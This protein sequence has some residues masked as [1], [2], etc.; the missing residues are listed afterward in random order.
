MDNNYGKTSHTSSQYRDDAKKRRSDEYNH[1]DRQH[2]HECHRRNNSYDSYGPMNDHR[3]DY[4]YVVDAAGGGGRRSANR[5]PGREMDISRRNYDNLGSLLDRGSENYSVGGD[6]KEEDSDNGRR[7]D[8]GHSRRRRRRKGHGSSRRR[9]RKGYSSSSRARSRGRRRSYS[10]SLPRKR[11]ERGSNRHDRDDRH[12][13]S[14]DYRISSRSRAHGRQRRSQSADDRRRNNHRERQNNNEGDNSLAYVVSEDSDNFLTAMGKADPVDNTGDLALANDR[15]MK[16]SKSVK[17]PSHR[18]DR[19][20]SSGKRR[21]SSP[22][23]ESEYSHTSDKRGGEN[24]HAYNPPP[25][26]LMENDYAERGDFSF[27]RRS[28]SCSSPPSYHRSKRESSRKRKKKSKRKSRRRHRLSSSCSLSRSRSRDRHHHSSYSLRSLSPTIHSDGKR[29]HYSRSRSFSNS[30]R[31]GHKKHDKERRRRRCSNGRKRVKKA[32]HRRRKSSTGGKRSHQSDSSKDDTVGHFHG[33]PGTMIDH[34]YQVI[35][36]VGL[37]T[38]GRVVECLNLRHPTYHRGNDSHRTVAIK[39]VRNI[40][41]YHDS[42]IIEAD[43]CERINREQSKQHKD[44]CAKML[45]RFN[46]SGHYCLVFECLGKSLYDFLKAHDYRPFPMYCVRDFARQLLE[47]LDFL[48]GFGLIHTDLKVSPSII[49]L[50][51]VYT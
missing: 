31:K 30:S 19:T 24:Y 25:P 21:H 47:T 18:E 2:N 43:I 3:E 10:N 13:D 37:G 5:R 48:H 23:S 27:K 45:D 16:S 9:K 28:R 36:D 4:D 12:Y 44:F 6:R 50:F 17:K 38:F 41:R 35:R 15:K 7:D 29:E 49:V 46:L 51:F 14:D 1:N 8:D 22:S 34:R 40:Q 33:G 32:K 39:I 42:A 11:R 26:G 20:R